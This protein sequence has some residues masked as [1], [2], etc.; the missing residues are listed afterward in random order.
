MI[1][2]PEGIDPYNVSQFLLVNNRYDVNDGRFYRED[3]SYHYC[4]VY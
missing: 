3:N 4:V 1:I 2:E